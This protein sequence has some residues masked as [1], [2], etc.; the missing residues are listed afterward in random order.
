MKNSLEGFKK[1]FE[2]EEE[3]ICKLEDRTMENIES[4]KQKKRKD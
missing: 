2:Q 3:I 1:N 4:E